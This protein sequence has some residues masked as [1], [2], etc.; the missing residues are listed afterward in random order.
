MVGRGAPS[1]SVCSQLEHTRDFSALGNRAGAYDTFLVLDG[2]T[3]QKER[4]GVA[5]G[6]PEA[7]VG[8]AEGAFT[9]RFQH[10]T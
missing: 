6:L 2:E 7:G 5:T 3:G 10:N 1:L 9:W 4:L 8:G